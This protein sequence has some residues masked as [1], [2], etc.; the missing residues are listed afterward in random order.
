MH[1]DVAEVKKSVRTYLMVFGSLMVLTVVTVA[2]AS[3]QVGVGLGIA[4]ALI[5]AATKASMVAAVFMHLSHEKR[6]IYGSLI[7]TG[8][9]F[10]VLLL[11]PAL[12]TFGTFGTHE[13][14]PAAAEAAEHGGH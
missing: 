6:W 14:A 9:F 11:L 12:T 13:A 8:V 1:S 2:V 4:I 10:L 3:L 5:I 7:L